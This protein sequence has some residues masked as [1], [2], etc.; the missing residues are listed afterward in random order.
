MSSLNVRTTYHIYYLIV[1][2][3][4][5]Y[6]NNFRASLRSAQFFLSTP[7]LTWNPGSAPDDL[8]MYITNVIADDESKTGLYEI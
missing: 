7:T 6:P 1:I 2:F 8:N 4:T 3:H 5:K